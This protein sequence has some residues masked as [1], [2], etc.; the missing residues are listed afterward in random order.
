[1]GLAEDE[2]GK[3]LG[4]GDQKIL[5]AFEA[6]GELKAEG[7]IRDIGICGSF[8]SRTHSRTNPDPTVST[9]PT[10]YPLPTLLRLSQLIRR[11]SSYNLTTLLSY[12]HSNLANNA[13]PSYLPSFPPN[14]KVFTASPLNMG[15]LSPQGPPAWHPAC[16]NSQ[17]AGLLEATRRARD[18][19]SDVWGAK[20]GIVDLSL[21]FGLRNLEDGGRKVPVLVGAKRQEEIHD[22][23][24][25]WR[26]VNLEPGLA[27]EERREAENKVRE[28]FVEAGWEDL[29]WE[30]PGRA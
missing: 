2:Q 20:G 5:K 12:S 25:V 22:A 30:S 17:N 27:D 23:V 16:S 13:F 21:G 15:L 10:G 26:E 8:I 4:E 11:H 19:A 3:I 1:M 24:R 28:V 14:L 18:V 7:L 9:T 29:S 6:L